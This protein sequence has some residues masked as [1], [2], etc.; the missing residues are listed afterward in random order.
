MQRRRKFPDSGN[1][2]TGTVLVPVELTVPPWDSCTCGAP[3]GWYGHER[4]CGE[5]EP[6]SECAIPDWNHT[7]SD[8]EDLEF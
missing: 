4:H 7:T 3:G 5:V 2:S 1:I 8:N 6:A